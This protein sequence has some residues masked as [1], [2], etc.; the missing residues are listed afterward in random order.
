MPDHSI[1]SPCR[2]HR[3]RISIMYVPPAPEPPAPPGS[4]EED[5]ESGDRG[6]PPPQPAE[7]HQ[8]A[9][10]GVQPIPPG[11][12]ETF[13]RHRNRE[14]GIQVTARSTTCDERIRTAIGNKNLSVVPP[15]DGHCRW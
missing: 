1:V 14:R 7:G 2:A 15:P 12:E 11:L 3:S 10:E 9:A 13:L 5:G 4:E 6:H 8:H